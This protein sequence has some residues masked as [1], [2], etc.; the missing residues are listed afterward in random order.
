VNNTLCILTTKRLFI[1]DKSPLD[2]PEESIESYATDPYPDGITMTDIIQSVRASDIIMYTT[3]PAF[4]VFIKYTPITKKF[5]SFA[6]NR[7]FA[8]VNC[9][10]VGNALYVYT[11]NAKIYAANIG[12]VKSVADF[13]VY[14]GYQWTGECSYY[15]GFIY[16]SYVDMTKDTPTN[17]LCR[18]ED[19]LTFEILSENF[20]YTDESLGTYVQGYGCMTYI[21]P[22]AY[23]APCIEM[24]PVDYSRYK[25]VLYLENIACSGVN[26]N[27][28]YIFKTNINATETANTIDPLTARITIKDEDNIVPYTDFLIDKSDENICCYVKLNG[29]HTDQ[30]LELDMIIRYI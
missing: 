5:T 17:V 20:P 25:A 9:I 24:C 3:D 22:E 19:G 18:S 10:L 30:N 29:N 4:N 1:F 2:I 15:D 11:A 6:A 27:G 12:E 26:T 8:I 21:S 13:R 28:Y 14:S 16:N 23:I 7:P